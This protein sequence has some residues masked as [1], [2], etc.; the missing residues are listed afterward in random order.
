M[1]RSGVNVNSRRLNV[2]FVH[3]RRLEH[4]GHVGG[5]L[6]ISVSL[7]LRRFR[8]E[9]APRRPIDVLCL[10]SAQKARRVHLYNKINVVI[11]RVDYVTVFFVC[12]PLPGPFARIDCRT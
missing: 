9:S 8:I 1:N 6:P 2:W 12:F 10:F 7:V 4:I 11:F 5:K 3:T